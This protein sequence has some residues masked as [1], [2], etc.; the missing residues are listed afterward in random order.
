[1]RNG[2]ALGL[3]PTPT[4][5]G[6]RFVVGRVRDVLTI[7]QPGGLRDDSQGWAE[8]VA[9]RAGAGFALRHRANL[10]LD[11]GNG[12]RI[13]M[14]LVTFEP[15]DAGALVGPSAKAALERHELVLGAGA[16]AIRHAVV[17][18][19]LTFVG[20]DG[21]IH[22]RRVGAIV[23]DERVFDA[24][25]ALA[26][27]DAAA[28]GISRPF[29]VDVWG[30]PR[31]DIERA[32]NTAP[33]M[34]HVLGIERSW[35]WPSPD[36]TLANVALKRLVGEVAYRHGRGDAVALD[37]T[38]VRQNITTERVPGVGSVTCHRAVMPAIRGAL[39][40][41]VRAGLGGGLGRYGG[42]YNPR[43]IRG[44]DSGGFL[45]RHSFGIALDL[46]VTRNTFGGRVEM[47]PRIVDIFRRWGFA[48]GGTWVR[49]DG[50]HFEYAPG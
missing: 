19:V 10:D 6:Y 7:W 44:G 1:V 36:E 2:A 33:P 16:A 43:L 39:T 42:C 47:D 12:W 18:S 48:W 9:R 5:L 22:P 11:A 23:R 25:I 8:D 14:S 15:A 49:A 17:G 37:P 32:L 21:R 34:Q 46:N 13:P 24:E 28:I 38:W 30:A 27:P 50:M 41:V 29:A 40:D 35:S 3:M 4:G 20:P 31:A 26:T 45:S